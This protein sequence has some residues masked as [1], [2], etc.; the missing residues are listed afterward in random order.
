MLMATLSSVPLSTALHCCIATG[1]QLG[2]AKNCVHATLLTVASPPDHRAK[3]RVRATSLTDG[4][5]PADGSFSDRHD[6]DRERGSAQ[7]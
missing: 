3:K 4:I 1:G 5:P 7:S 2:C 6:G